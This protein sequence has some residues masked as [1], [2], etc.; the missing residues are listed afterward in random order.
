MNTC[1]NLEDSQ[2]NYCVKKKLEKKLMLYDSIYIKFQKSKLTYG[3]S[4]P[5]TASG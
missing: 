1:N 5:M 4:I 2:N 3:D